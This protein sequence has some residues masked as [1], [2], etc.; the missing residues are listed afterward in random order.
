MSQLYIRNHCL[1]E[2][3]LILYILR[4]FALL[5]LTIPDFVYF[6]LNSYLDNLWKWKPVPWSLKA[7]HW[8]VILN[9]QIS[10]KSLNEIK[11][12]LVSALA[13]HGKIKDALDLYKEI[14]QARGRLEP[15]AV[16]SLI[17]SL[18]W[19][20]CLWALYC[21]H[22]YCKLILAIQ[23]CI[24][25]D[26]SDGELNRL[27]ELLGELHDPLYWMNGCYRVILYCVRHQHLR[28]SMTFNNLNYLICLTSTA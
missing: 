1:S 18:L 27:V 28:L 7:Y 8:Q 13:S 3:V 2:Y 9:D 11:S 26:G 23:E 6:S 22:F 21:F 10:V 19:H 12:T 14:K 15:K 5:F 4:F 20:L 17:V 16:G 25:S 24:E